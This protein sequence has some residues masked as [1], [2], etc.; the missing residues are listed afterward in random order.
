MGVKGKKRV[1][2]YREQEILCLGLADKLV[3]S[4][5]PSA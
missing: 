4:A 1:A 2:T 3:H 5:R